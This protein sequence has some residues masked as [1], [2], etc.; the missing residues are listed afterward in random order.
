[1]A[2]IANRYWTLLALLAAAAVMYSLGF[3]VGFWLFIAA[4]VVFD[5]AFWHRLF[6][7]TRR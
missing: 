4:G 5:L 7:R 3:I 6:K 2:I 1:V